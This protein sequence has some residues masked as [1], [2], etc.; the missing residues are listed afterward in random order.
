MTSD[1]IV[2]GWLCVLFV[3]VGLLLAFIKAKNWYD[4]RT[5]DD[6]ELTT[7]GNK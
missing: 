5:W 6:V 3:V 1:E 2:F 7:R 4:R